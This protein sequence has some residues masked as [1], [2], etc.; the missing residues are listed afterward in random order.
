MQSKTCFTDFKTTRSGVSFDCRGEYGTLSLNLYTSDRDDLYHGGLECHHNPDKLPK[1]YKEFY[2]YR[3][4]CFIN[5]GPCYHNGSSLYVEERL[6]PLWSRMLGSYGLNEAIDHMK[7][8]LEMVEYP[9][10]MIKEITDEMAS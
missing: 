7:N 1:D 3:E 8:H 10:F 6:G 9:R 4:F 5:G 2:L